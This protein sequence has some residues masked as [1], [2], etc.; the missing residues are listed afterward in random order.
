MVWSHHALIWQ[1]L[2]THGPFSDILSRNMDAFR[3]TLLYPWLSLR[4]TY[5]LKA[6]AGPTF[7]VYLGS[8]LRGGEGCHPFRRSR[9]HLEGSD[10]TGTHDLCVKGRAFYPLNHGCSPTSHVALF[11][12]AEALR[13]RWSW[14]LYYKIMYICY[15]CFKKW[16]QLKFNSCFSGFFRS[17]T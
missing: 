8:F 17:L 1:V 15:I 10:D 6:M 12:L 3:A 2:S 13:F 7:T 4:L 11:P 16:T 5:F 9:S 14:M